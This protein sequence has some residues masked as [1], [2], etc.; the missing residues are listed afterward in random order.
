M[1]HINISNHACIY[2]PVSKELHTCLSHILLCTYCIYPYVTL[3]LCNHVV[4]IYYQFQ[5]NYTLACEA[6]TMVAHNLDFG[7]VKVSAGMHAGPNGQ[8]TASVSA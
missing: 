7:E 5:E 1:G 4:I 6:L 8:L 3:S 2:H